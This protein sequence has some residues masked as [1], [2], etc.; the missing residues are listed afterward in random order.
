M[1][2]YTNSWM[3]AP[4]ADSTDRSLR[5]NIAKGVWK[6]IQGSILHRHYLDCIYH[7]GD[8]GKQT[9]HVSV[10]TLRVKDHEVRL[11]QQRKIGISAHDDKMYL[12][13]DGVSQVPWGHKSITTGI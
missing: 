2:S 12:L 7:D 10:H 13:S 11:E 5:Q 9:R 3:L 1:M 6:K 4:T 8:A